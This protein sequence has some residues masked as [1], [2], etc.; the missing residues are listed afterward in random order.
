M[1]KKFRKLKRKVKLFIERFMM[2]IKNQEYCEQCDGDGFVS[3]SC[4]GY[5][6]KGNDYMICP[7]CKEHCD[8]CEEECEECGGVGKVPSKHHTHD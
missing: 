5:D 2:I 1:K 8:G 6:M 7:D 3:Y 4:C